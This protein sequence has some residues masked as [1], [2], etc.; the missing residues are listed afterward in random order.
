MDIQG[1]TLI[2]GYTGMTLITGFS[3]IARI[4]AIDG[5]GE[6]PG[7]GGLTHSPWAAKQEGMRQLL[8]LNGI[9][10]GSG[11][12]ALTHHGGKILGPVFSR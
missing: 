1:S 11:N 8:V 4:L 3:V 6:Y 9:F 7:A 12:M 10:K 5:L 2:K